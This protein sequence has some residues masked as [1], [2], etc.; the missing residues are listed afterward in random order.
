LRWRLSACLSNTGFIVDY[1][2]GKDKKLDFHVDDSEVTINVCLGESFEGGS[3]YFGGIRCDAHQQSPIPPKD[4]VNVPHS[5]GTALLHAGESGL[6][7]MMF[8]C[9]LLF[10]HRK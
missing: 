3:L 7:R 8:I 2:I 9:L 5:V 4:H 1:E 10:G 6:S